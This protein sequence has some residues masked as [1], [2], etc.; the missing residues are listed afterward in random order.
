MFRSSL[1]H[2]QG[3][4]H[5]TSIHKTQLNYKIDSPTYL[6]PKVETSGAAPNSPVPV[7]AQS[8]A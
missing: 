6:V 1:D 4:L 2:L 8:K 5:Q 3:V 7:A